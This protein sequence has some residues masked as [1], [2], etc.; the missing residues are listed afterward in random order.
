MSQLAPEMRLVPMTE[1]EYDAFYEH[2]IR[3]YAEGLVRAGN[4]RPDQAVQLSRQ[5]CAPVLSNGLASPMRRPSVM[6][7]RPARGGRADGESAR[8]ERAWPCREKG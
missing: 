8:W 1:A 5:Q 6:R 4:A 3:D 2:V 7:A